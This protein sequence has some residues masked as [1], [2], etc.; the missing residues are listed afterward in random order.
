MSITTV[1]GR[2][3]KEELGITLTHEHLLWDLRPLVET[4]E[5]N[6][7]PYFRDKVGLANRYLLYG[8]PYTLLDNAYNDSEEVALK[9]LLAFKAAG[10]GT[11]VDV[12]TDEIARNPSALKRLSEKSGVNIVMGCGYYLGA[13]QTRE[14]AASS[15]TALAKRIIRDITEGVGDTGIKAGVI[16][17]IGTGA[18]VSEEEWRAV[19]AAGIASAETGKSIH[20]H[21]ALWEDNGLAV[22]DKLIK[23]GAEAEKICINHIDVHLREDYCKRLLDR[24]VYIEF[25]NFGKEFFIP[26]RETGVLRGRFAYDIE[27]VALIKRL[28]DKGYIKRILITNDICLKSMLRQ[29]GGNGYAHINLNVVQMLLDGGLTQRDVDLLLKTNPA[30]FL[31]RES[32]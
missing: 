10:G 1:T 11:V 14:T 31:D 30:E 8:D 27:R 28:A 5:T 22:S 15:V 29:F 6:P 17:E 3:K 16:G 24:G 2:I 20:V 23:D 9:E 12:T 18:A 21:T 19:A 26:K 32:K 25:D 7:N 4:T 13:T